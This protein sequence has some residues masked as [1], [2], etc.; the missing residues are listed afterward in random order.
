MLIAPDHHAIQDKHCAVCG[1]TLRGMTVNR[2][3]F[4]CTHCQHVQD[5][6]A[7]CQ[8][9]PSRCFVCRG[10]TENAEAAFWRDLPP[11]TMV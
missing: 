10:E 1:E 6:C 3:R 5:L 7:F 2:V 9:L 11:G 8:I 4:A